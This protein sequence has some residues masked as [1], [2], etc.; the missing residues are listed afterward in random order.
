LNQFNFNYWI[1]FKNLNFRTL[2]I[3]S[4]L[5]FIT[6][7]LLND[8][9]RYIPVILLDIIEELVFFIVLFYQFF[10]FA[11]KFL[12]LLWIFFINFICFKL[13]CLIMKDNILLFFITAFFALFALRLFIRM[14]IFPQS[15]L[16]LA[17]NYFPIL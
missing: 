17:V 8:F 1:N 10:L 7:Y 11:V 9:V 12:L 13:N 5:F 16:K 3:T 2:N 14:N 4:F 15:L 6:F